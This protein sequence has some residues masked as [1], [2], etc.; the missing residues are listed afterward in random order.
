MYSSY[1]TPNTPYK[2]CKPLFC[3]FYNISTFVVLLGETAQRQI[4]RSCKGYKID[5]R[6]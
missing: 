6:A 5:L 2:S 1:K 4:Y 3:T